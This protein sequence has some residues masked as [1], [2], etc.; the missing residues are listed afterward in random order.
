[1]KIQLTESQAW[2]IALHDEI[3]PSRGLDA[4]KMVAGLTAMF[5]FRSPVIEKPGAAEFSDGAFLLGDQNIIIS[6]L[7]L[8]SDGIN[9]VVPTSTDDAEIVLQTA[10]A[11][12]FDFGVRQPTSAPVHFHQSSI[13]ADFDH[14]LESI[15]PI[16]LMEMITQALP[17]VG[18]S[19]IMN[20]STNFDS[21]DIQDRR[22]AGVNPSL[23]KIE[24][25]ANIPYYLN[26]Y[27]CLANMSTR[28]HEKILERFENYAAAQVER[29]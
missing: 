15:F 24:R 4:P 7:S 14:G 9:V 2:W 26:R 27:F 3:R 1:M 5:S 13:V 20:I 16:S 6:K 12:L 19:K 8:F 28:N 25:R 21:N 11:Y 23:F 29:L 22:W 17:I 18:T 10:L